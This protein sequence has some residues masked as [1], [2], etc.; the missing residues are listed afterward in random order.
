MGRSPSLAPAPE[1]QPAPRD[2]E[3]R[4]ASERIAL[5]SKISADAPPCLWAC[6]TVSKYAGDRG[7]EGL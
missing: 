4:G 5:Q 6:N 1:E 3:E 7:T 2:D